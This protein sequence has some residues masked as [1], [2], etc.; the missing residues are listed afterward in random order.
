MQDESG[1]GKFVVE[2]LD[3]RAD[4]RG[5]PFHEVGN[6]DGNVVPIRQRRT[7][8]F[9]PVQQQNDAGDLAE[10][11]EQIV[12]PWNVDR[13]DQPD[14]AIDGEGVT[15]PLHQFLGMGQPA[16]A[17]VVAVDFA[18]VGRLSACF[19]ENSLLIG[20]YPR[21]GNP[22]RHHHSHFPGPRRPAM[23]G[24]VQWLALEVKYLDRS[25]A[26]YEAFLDLDV[27]RESDGEVILGAGETD[28]VLRSPG[29]VPR[30]GLHVHYAFSI[31]HGEYDQWWDRL[32]ERFDLI[33]HTFGEARSLYFYDPESNCVELG[34]RDV[35]GPGI[36][37]LFE[38]VLE[39]EDLD[40]AVGFYETLGF[41]IT[42]R[43]ENRRR[44][45]LTTG[46]FDLELWEPQ[47]GLAD[48]RG[49][50]HVD[51]G[52]TSADPA[53]TVEPVRSDCLA[54]ADMENGMCIR[55]QDG[56]YLSLIE[57]DGE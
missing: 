25:Q 20:V 53:A 2:S 23:L 15:G 51:F 45:R 38:I 50:V 31:P 19:H 9:V 32:D 56:H 21:T 5:N 55:D 37:G 4:F 47:L 28:L 26:F 30:G 41:D 40:R 52:V 17:A 8:P 7:V 13:I 54:V 6:P 49:G 27:R 42:S 57:A 34:Q 12:Q 44:V 3:G 11:G 22:F 46:E 36:D 48:A 35:D 18:P 29:P 16:D 10:L 33:E 43:G 1:I 24:N 14:L 39:V